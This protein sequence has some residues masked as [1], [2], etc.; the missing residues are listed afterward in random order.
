MMTA[1]AAIEAMVAAM[2]DSGSDVWQQQQKVTAMATV[3]VTVAAM[4][5]GASDA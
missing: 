4:R 2:G 5:D 1:M 3:S